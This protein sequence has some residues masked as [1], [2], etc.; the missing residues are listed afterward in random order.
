MA[1]NFSKLEITRQFATITIQRSD[2]MNALPPAAHYELSDIFDELEKNT[3]IRAVILTGS[4]RTFCTGYDLKHNLETGII[5]LPKTGFGG[6]AFRADYPLPVI[7]AVN[8]P[9]MG[10]G[11]EMAL[12]CDLIVAS[13]NATFALPEPKVGWAAL[14]GGVQRL[15]RAIGTKRAMS[16]ILTGRSVSAAEG[17]ELGFVNQVVPAEELMS[18]AKAW[19][20]QIAQCAPLAIRCSKQAAYA[21]FDQ[22]NFATMMNPK[23]YPSAAAM[24][25]SEDAQEG[26]RAFSERRKPIW[27]GQ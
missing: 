6:L 25:T 18:A 26:K 27:R 8:G 21:S 12:A 20:D 19:A 7:A 23:T 1:G 17:F 3:S 22:S 14:G 2:Q 15:P 24:F 10:G 11:F 9:A 5:D 16:M 4:G 13:E